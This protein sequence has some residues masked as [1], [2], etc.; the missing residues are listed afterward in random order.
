MKVAILQNEDPN[1]SEKWRLACEKFNVTYK[2]IDLTAA[3][4]LEKIQSDKYDFYL[5]KPPGLLTHYKSLYD[6]RLY[7]I[8][9]VLKHTT[10]PSFEECYIYENKKLLSYF[11]K[12]NNIPHPNTKVFYYREEAMDFISCCTF[13]IVVKT[14]IGASGSGVKILKSKNKAQRYIS[15]AFSGRGIKRRFGPNRVTGSPTKWFS[16]ALKS[17]EYFNKKVKEYFSIY[18][19]GEKDFAIIQEYIPHDFE[20]RAVRIGDSYFAHK[21][22][23]V[24]EKASGSKG[25]DFVNPPESILNFTRMLCEKCN[26]QFM[27]VDLFEEGNGGYLVNELQTI[28][29][30]VQDHILSVNGNPGRY[31]YSN[32]HWIFEEGDFNVN[33]SFDLR[34]K[35]AMELYEKEK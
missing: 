33:E 24:G 21:K 3:D 19:H 18:K 7:I 32:N 26:F 8:S 29:G 4:W 30:H 20:W 17:P 9:K 25:I 5:L 22:I 6:E 1:S 23:K 14:S 28:F 2:V 16:R 34:L 27:A 12:A 13:P 35:V 31:I 11:L 15:E 10:F